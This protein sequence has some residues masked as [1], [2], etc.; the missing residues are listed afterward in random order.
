MKCR[1][2]KAPL[3]E[4]FL[5]L[6]VTPLSNAF[7]KKEELTRN[8][9][10]YPL[11]AFV[12][13]ECL[14]VQLEEY[15]SPKKIFTDYK[16]FSSYSESWLKHAENYVDLV[17][18]RFSLNANNQVDFDDYALLCLKIINVDPNFTKPFTHIIVDEAQ[19]LNYIQFRIVI[20][21]KEKLGAILNFITP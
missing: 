3:N 8:E 1:F 2:C 13:S 4:I 5:N 7:L 20:L 14:L 15:E 9:T 18:K 6:G 19:D 17:R 11:C 16:Y 21:I 12:C 10:K